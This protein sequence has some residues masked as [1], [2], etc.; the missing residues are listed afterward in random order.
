MLSA[1][2]ITMFSVLCLFSVNAVHIFPPTKLIQDLYF[3]WH[4]IEVLF[5]SVT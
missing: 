5:I 1:S 2:W 4:H 3:K